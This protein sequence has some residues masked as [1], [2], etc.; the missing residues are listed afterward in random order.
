MKGVLP[1]W[2]NPTGNPFA[3]VSGMM[4]S[5]NKSWQQGSDA[6]TQALANP[7]KRQQAQEDRASA[8][9]MN[10]LK[11]Q[12]LNQNLAKGQFG[13]DTQQER[14]DADMLSKQLQQSA[15]RNTARN[16]NQ[17]FNQR[18]LEADIAAKNR[19]DKQSLFNQEMNFGGEY[20]DTADRRQQQA[21]LMRLKQMGPESLTYANQLVNQLEAP[22]NAQTARSAQEEVLRKEAVAAKQKELDRTSKEGIASEKL[23]DKKK[24]K[25][26]YFAGFNDTVASGLVTDKTQSSLSGTSK[27]M[28]E[29]DAAGGYTYKGNIYNIPKIAMK[30]INAAIAQQSNASW[31]PGDTN[32]GRSNVETAIEDYIRLTEN[33]K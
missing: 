2:R 4:N 30:N 7:L 10:A 29:M 33:I 16:S 32:I 20:F 24:G 18:G 21:E 6:L 31:V 8:E 23:K 22:S 9:A 19:A 3:G 25:G 5:A 15:A 11:M 13:L 1:T 26:S 14:F 27:L 12:G 28:S 17:T